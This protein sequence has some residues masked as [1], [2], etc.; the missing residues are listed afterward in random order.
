MYNNVALLHPI[1]QVLSHGASALFYL[2]PNQNVRKPKTSQKTNLDNKKCLGRG[3]MQTVD[4]AHSF[5][6]HLSACSMPGTSCQAA[7]HK[8]ADL[9]DGS[10]SN[11]NSL[12]LE[13]RVNRRQADTL[14]Q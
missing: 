14:R 3:G 7:Q 12:I 11:A 13:A 5:N 4:I 10:E 2:F 6:K 8:T 9:N 1:G